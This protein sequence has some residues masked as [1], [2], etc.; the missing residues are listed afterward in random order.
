MSQENLYNEE[1]R[2]KL[3]DM[4][5][6]IDFAMMETGLGQRPTHIIPMST[7]K[8][9]E[10][11]KIWFLSNDNS[12]HNKNIHNDGYLQLIYSNP[13]EMEFLTIYGTAE[14]SKDQNVLNEL[15]S[16]ADDTWFDG[17]EDP[18]LSAIRVTPKS[19]HYWDSQAGKFITLFKIGMGAIS[20]NKQ[21][22]G[23]EGDLH[24]NSEV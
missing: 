1:A 8:V 3:K 7:K 9:D 21:D 2:K 20:G 16:K 17:V 19:A 6:D 4:V 24:L 15:Y 10:D 14:I 23:R 5:D 22:V 11:G 18:K 12:E 13:N